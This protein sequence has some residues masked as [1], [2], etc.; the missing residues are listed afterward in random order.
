MIVTIQRELDSCCP[1]ASCDSKVC[2]LH[3]LYPMAGLK[4]ANSI[5]QLRMQYLSVPVLSQMNR[6]TKTGMN[7][8]QV[9]RCYT[10]WAFNKKVTAF[11]AVFC[12]PRPPASSC[13]W[14][15][16]CGAVI[17]GVRRAPPH[18]LAGSYRVAELS[19]WCARR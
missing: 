14:S 13:H 19:A 1:F 17:L 8:L 7:V 11:P 3:Y 18:R 4:F 15:R 10:V 16:P 9:W 6:C 2:S 12:L 5:V